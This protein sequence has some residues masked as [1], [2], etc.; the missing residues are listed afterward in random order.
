MRFFSV[1]G[2]FQ[3][4]NQVTSENLK[5]W[6]VLVSGNIENVSR[7]TFHKVESFKIWIRNEGY[8]IEMISLAYGDEDIGLGK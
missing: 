8:E 6:S 1:S 2:D 4:V 5:D 3:K 7:E